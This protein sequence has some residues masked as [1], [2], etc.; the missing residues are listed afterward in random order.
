MA[1]K[2]DKKPDHVCG[3][4]YTALPIATVI[5]TES[6][7]P[8]L[9]RRKET[10]SYGTKKLIE[11]SFKTGDTCIIIEDLITSGSSVLETRQD[12]KNEGLN[13][14]TALVVVDR[15]QG[16]RK[17]LE[18]AGINVTSIFTMSQLI[19]ILCHAGKISEKTVEE[20]KNYI[21]NSKAPLKINNIYDRLTQNFTNRAAN[22]KSPLAAKLFKLMSDKQTTLCLAADH[23]K[24]QE[25]LDIA[26]V[27]GPHIAVLK[28][29]VDIIEDF[30]QEFVE[31]LMGLAEKHKFFIMEDRKFADIGQ[32]VSQ[33]FS[34]GIYSIAKWADFI[35]VHLISGQ[36][37]LQGVNNVSLT[38]PSARGVFVVAEMSSQG[39]LTT[40]SYA[41]SSV[42]ISS[43]FK[44]VVGFVCQSNIFADPGL[45][46]LTPGV[47]LVKSTDDLGQQ[48]N[49][50]HE[51]VN[52]GGDLIVV[53]RGIT[54]A[55][56]KLTAIVEY[57]KALWEAYIN[58][59]KQD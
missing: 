17:N 38:L 51:V 12:L 48:Y 36:G 37:I 28:M 3:V 2:N 23:N 39:A 47:K 20:V 30:D 43:N 22:T 14:T 18:K 44:N 55:K 32:I 52:A 21:S 16:G 10:K 29:H 59:I 6:K 50:P 7:I 53:G 8:M 56:D 25:I 26:N 34:K 4:P 57:K 19:E 46:Q 13:V 9:I 58:R 5:S 33:Q 31:K 15:E 41:K 40:E 11:G 45:I 1:D 42:E 24:C 54:E 49:T 35:T 27:A